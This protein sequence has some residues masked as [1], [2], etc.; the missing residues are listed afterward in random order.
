MIKKI[1]PPP[2]TCTCNIKNINGVFMYRDIC[3]V[4]VFIEIFYSIYLSGDLKT[5][6]IFM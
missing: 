3:L 4:Y 1:V 6:L 5:Q 2:P